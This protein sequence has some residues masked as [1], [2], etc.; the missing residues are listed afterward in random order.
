MLAFMQENGPYSINDDGET[1][2]E[3][4]FSWNREANVLYIEQ[5]AGV[6]YSICGDK[7]ECSF[8]DNNVSVDNLAAVLA[9]FEK[10]PEYKNH[11]LYISGESYAGIYV[12]YLVNQIHHHNV[13]NVGKPEV[14]KPNLKGM[15]VGNGVTNWKYDTNPAYIELANAH[16]FMNPDDYAQMKTLNCDYS[17]LEFGGVQSDECMALL[18]NF[19]NDTAG[20]NIYDTLGKCYIQASKLEKDIKSVLH[21]TG[22]LKMIGGGQ[23]RKAATYDNYTPWMSKLRNKKEGLGVVPPCVD[24]APVVDYLNK[25]EVLEALHIPAGLPA[26]D[27][28][29]D[30]I[31]YTVLPIGSQWIWESLKGQ[32]RMLKYSGDTDGA[33]PLIGTRNWINSLNRDILEAWRPFY[34]ADSDTT[35]HLAGYIEEYDGLTLGTVHGAGHMTPQYKPAESYWLIFNWLK[36]LPI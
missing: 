19:E 5:P 11:E 29:L 10:Y 15:M 31:D 17:Q 23:E 18:D 25:P 9:W 7:S 32:Y 30:G 12:P 16:S 4:A 22:G 28:C 13:A 8:N 36:N 1:F 34:V 3:S 33:V 24:G 21:H 2:T 6:G 14:Y 27:M 20:V 35:Q 26:W